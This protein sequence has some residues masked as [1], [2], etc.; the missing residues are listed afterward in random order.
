MAVGTRKR[1][2]LAVLAAAAVILCVSAVRGAGTGSDGAAAQGGVAPAK[3]CITMKGLKEDMIDGS[4]RDL[5]GKYPYNVGGS[6]TYFDYLKDAH[7]KRLATVYGSANVPS[8]LENGDMAEYSDERIEFSD[9]AVEAQGI[10]NITEAEKGAWQYLPVVGTEGKY[11]G[12]IGKRHFQITKMGVA[13]KG[14]IE[15]CPA[16]MSKPGDAAEHGDAPSERDSGV[17]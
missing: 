10:Y 1:A 12:M 16:G 11:R 8:R 14:W 13:L 5:G 17:S 3:S 9:G 15:L 2:F 6:A 7:G 4:V